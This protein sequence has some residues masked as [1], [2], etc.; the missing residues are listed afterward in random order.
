MKRKSCGRE[1]FRTEEDTASVG[2]WAVAHR[3]LGTYS[4]VFD[5]DGNSVLNKVAISH[6]GVET[7]KK[8]QFEIRE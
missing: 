5:G 6:N 7:L 8:K 3:L 2:G 4:I 1:D